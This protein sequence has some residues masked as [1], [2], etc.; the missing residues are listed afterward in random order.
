MLIPTVTVL[1]TLGKLFSLIFERK[2]MISIKT[3][4][5]NI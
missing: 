2:V 1:M 3:V 4:V 5:V